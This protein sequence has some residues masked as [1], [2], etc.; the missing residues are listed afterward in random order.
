ME[1]HGKLTV[2]FGTPQQREIEVKDYIAFSAADDRKVSIAEL[3]DDQGYIVSVENYP[4][5]GRNTA[6]TMW[7]SKESLQAVGF[8]F[9]MFNA[10][11]GW[12]P[13]QVIEEVFGSPDFVFYH[14]DG[15]KNPF[16]SFTDSKTD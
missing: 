11:K 12:E 7:L 10:A 15:L 9:H 6:N 1:S 8:A 13:D 16:S 3:V 14:S 2:G 5:S 4:S